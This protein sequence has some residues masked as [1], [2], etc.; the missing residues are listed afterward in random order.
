MRTTAAWRRPGGKLIREV[1]SSNRFRSA[2]RQAPQCCGLPWWPKQTS[3]P[4]WILATGGPS[5]RDFKTDS[6]SACH[7]P[8]GSAAQARRRFFFRGSR[9]SSLK[10]MSQRGPT[11]TVVESMQLKPGSKN[12]S[13]FVNVS[14]SRVRMAQ[15]RW[16]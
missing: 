13:G 14:K 6:G 1:T 15:M 9:R 10:T 3:Q 11:R 16:L 4:P 2:V 7:G 12:S 5:T 8:A